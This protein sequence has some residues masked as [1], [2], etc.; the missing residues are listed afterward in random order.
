MFAESRRPDSSWGPPAPNA[1]VWL[2]ARAFIQL[3]GGVNTFNT[4]AH[5]VVS[6]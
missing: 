4:N 1:L 3:A 2:L 5:P 6:V